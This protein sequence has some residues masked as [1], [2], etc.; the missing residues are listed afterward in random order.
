[1]KFQ[2]VIQIVMELRLQFKRIVLSVGIST[3]SQ[4]GMSPSTSAGGLR[5]V[6]CFLVVGKGKHGT[7]RV[8]FSF[9]SEVRQMIVSP[10]S[11]DM[12]D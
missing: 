9:F 1:M 7:A 6:F 2:I 11:A 8:R 5:Y 4:R 12:L 3:P 10:V